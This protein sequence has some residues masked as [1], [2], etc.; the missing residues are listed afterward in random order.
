MLYTEL[1]NSIWIYLSS[2]YL[3]T[4]ILVLKSLW[5]G[6]EKGAGRKKSKEAVALGNFDTFILKN[7]ESEILFWI[8]HEW[9]HLW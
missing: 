5:K 8:I 4:W 2:I 7:Q 9:F 6:L 1:F 3:T